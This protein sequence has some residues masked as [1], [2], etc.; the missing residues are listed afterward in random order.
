MTRCWIPAQ[1]RNDPVKKLRLPRGKQNGAFPTLQRYNVLQPLRRSLFVVLGEPQLAEA[2]GFWG[3][4][5]QLVF[6]EVLE[7]LLER[8]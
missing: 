2:D 6:A 3:D 8:H 1:G 5:G 4:L 7:R